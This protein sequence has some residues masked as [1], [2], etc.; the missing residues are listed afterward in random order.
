M[1]APPPD[2]HAG[3]MSSQAGVQ[4]LFSP[5]SVAVVG[6]SEAGLG[7]MVYQN[8]HADIYLEGSIA[9]AL[10]ALGERSVAPQLLGLLANEQVDGSVRGSIVD[11][12]AILIDNE[13]DVQYLATLLPGSHPDITDNI[14]RALWTASRRVTATPRLLGMRGRATRGAW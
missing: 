2:R 9:E 3:E 6:A 7:S 12:L 8:L 14:Y 11:A 1:D 10:G 5:E 13:K 4:R